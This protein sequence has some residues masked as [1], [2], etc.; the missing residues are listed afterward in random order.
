MCTP[1]QRYAWHKCNLRYPRL[2]LL[3]FRM[4]LEKEI[5]PF[6][7]N[8]WLSKCLLQLSFLYTPVRNM[9][10]YY[11]NAAVFELIRY[12]Q[13]S[14]QGLRDWWGCS[15]YVMMFLLTVKTFKIEPGCSQIEIAACPWMTKTLIFSIFHVFCQ[16]RVNPSLSAEQHTEQLSTPFSSSSHKAALGRWCSKI[17][18]E[19]VPTALS[20]PIFLFC[21]EISI[22]ILKE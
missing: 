20:F 12:A 13:T 18:P 8:T 15:L 14:E 1:T 10:N 5:F 16:C 19:Y 6:M 7:R 9:W 4:P 22:I 3:L 2:F 17:T 11:C 21:I